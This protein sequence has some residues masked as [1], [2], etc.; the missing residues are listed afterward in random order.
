MLVSGSRTAAEPDG[1]AATVSRCEGVLGM[2]YSLVNIPAL[3]YDL[4]RRPHGE[5][6]ALVLRVA[7]ASGPDQLGPLAARHPG[8]LRD[9][10]W[11]D[12]VTEGASTES[13]RSALGL[14]DLALERAQAGDVSSSSVL[15]GRLELAALGNLPALERVLRHDILDWT[16]LHSGDLAVQDPDFAKAADVLLDAAASA[17]SSQR[18]SDE[19][20]R[21]MAAPFLAARPETPAS[22]GHDV[23]DALLDDIAGSDAAA[24][25]SWRAAVEAGRPGT[26]RWAPSMHQATW[27]LHLSDRLRPAADAQLAAVGAF[28]DGGFDARDAAYGVWNAVSGAVQAAVAADLLADDDH[29]VLT[30]VWCAVRAGNHPHA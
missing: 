5:Q 7:L 24:R 15:L 22:T 4:V 8:S 11:A 2:P 12:V 9:A 6:V 28:R 17:Y 16:W 23:V 29:R 30:R 21:A 25:G 18:L 14:A 27:A 10:R 13:V 26:R 20:R 19:R 1:R 3:G